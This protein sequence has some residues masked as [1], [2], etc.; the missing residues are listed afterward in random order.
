M[1][2]QS[3]HAFRGTADRILGIDDSRGNI[4]WQKDR[5]LGRLRGK[6]PDLADLFADGAPHEQVLTILRLLRNTVHGQLLQSLTIDA[7]ARRST[8][9]YLPPEDQEGILAA[10]CATGGLPAWGVSAVGGRQVVDPEPFAERLITLTVDL[11][12]DV[13]RHTPVEQLEHVRLTPAD[14]QPPQDQPGSANVFGERN[15]LGIRWQ[16]GF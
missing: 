11:L 15:R 2:N 6:H 14:C 10:M 13:M 8:G 16:L 1:P 3:V 7:G 12:N 5:W 9:I 4:G